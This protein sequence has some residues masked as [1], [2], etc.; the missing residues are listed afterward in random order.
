MIHINRPC[1]RLLNLLV[2]VLWRTNKYGILLVH[3]LTQLEISYIGKNYEQLT[4]K[5]LCV[6]A[7]GGQKELGVGIHATYW[8]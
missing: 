8:R 6:T 2:H 3:V 4:F 5:S 7:A 1:Q